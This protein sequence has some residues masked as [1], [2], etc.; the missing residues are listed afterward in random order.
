MEPKQTIRESGIKLQGTRVVVK[1]VGVWTTLDLGKIDLGASTVTDDLE[2][3][4]VEAAGVDCVLVKVGDQVVY[5]PLT[6]TGFTYNKEIYKM[7]SKEE[8]IVG[9]VPAPSKLE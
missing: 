8:G 7:I 4:T 2:L 6:G 5:G 9:V 1:R 3:G